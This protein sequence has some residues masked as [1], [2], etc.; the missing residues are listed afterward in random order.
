[1]QLQTVC[2]PTRGK[3]MTKNEQRKFVKRLMTSIMDQ[4]ITEVE[5]NKIPETW[6]GFEL[7]QLVIDRIKSGVNWNAW[8][9]DREKK[10]LNDC[11]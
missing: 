8:T 7:R 9:P 6:R 10:Y 1:M 4:V 3:I 5:E 11:P 2:R